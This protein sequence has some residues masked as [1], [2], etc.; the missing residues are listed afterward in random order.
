MASQPWR[1]VGVAALAALPAVGIA[2]I[3]LWTEPG[4]LAFRWT[5]TIAILASLGLGLSA[6]HSAVVR[7][8]QT[9]ANLLAAMREGDFSHRARSLDPQDDLGLLYAETNALADMLRGQRLGVIEAT[10]LLQTVMAEIDAAVF[11]FEDESGR[12]V[13]AN[14]G[15]A[16]LLDEPAERLVG[17]HA[18]DL[19]LADCFDGETPRVLEQRG[20]YANRW[21]LRRSSFRQDGRAHTLVLLTDVRRALQVEEREAW[22]RLIRVLSHEINNSL[23]PIRSFAGSLRS[24]VDRSPR[25]DASDADL[26]EGLGVIEQ[27]AESLGRFIAAY[28]RLARLP[29][30]VL[31][32]MQLGDW[33]RRVVSLE[34]R[35]PI[36]VQAGPDRTLMADRDQLD[37]L[38]I[39]LVRNAVDASQETG[40]GVSV[41]WALRPDEVELIVEDEGTGLAAGTANLFV[42]FYTTKPGGSGIGLALSRR[43]AEAHGGTLQLENRTDRAGCRAIVRIPVQ[44]QARES[45]GAFQS[46]SYRSAPRHLGGAPRERPS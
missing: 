3:L 7:P 10:A 24:L 13:F 17:R 21:E 14:P 35:L 5:A 15:G 11:T 22:Q 42:P 45:T 27:R 43:I 1:L 29:R 39:N 19:G 9:I 26:R 4:S 20:A 2:L 33:V 30:P 6:L 32:P 37:Q 18:A 12:L 38:L 8:L 28:A 46:G 31:A 23:A 34:G 41:R 44:T 36:L 16:R 40:G 25:G